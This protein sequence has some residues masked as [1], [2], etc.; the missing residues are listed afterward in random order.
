[1]SHSRLASSALSKKFLTTAV[2]SFLGMAAA[3]PVSAAIISLEQ[4]AYAVQAQTQPQTTTTTSDAN[5]KQYLQGYT[6]GYLASVKQDNSSTVQVGNCSG[7]VSQTS[8]VASD[9]TA[10][11]VETTGATMPTYSPL[12]KQ[13]WVTA[14]TSV[15][16]SFNTYTSS[17]STTNNINTDVT[18]NKN[19]TTT[20][21]SNN[22]ANSNNNVQS[23]LTISNSTGVV[24]ASGTSATGDVVT[25][26][27]AKSKDS[28]NT[29]TNN[30]SVAIDGSFNTNSNNKTTTVDSGNTTTNTT[31][32]TNVTDTTNN[33][34]SVDDS[35]NKVDATLNNNSNNTTIT[36]E[37]EHHH[38]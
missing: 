31:N 32:T 33:T 7:P 25:G 22:T 16:N 14:N 30:T 2:A 36:N 4:P 8:T 37:E 5:Y 29:T 3:V 12:S 20:I 6:Q 1:M 17:T 9:N 21:D 18:V 28:N 26:V 24:A 13:A 11:V 27:D 19:H 34:T 23:A 15:N 35:Y 38:V 10:P